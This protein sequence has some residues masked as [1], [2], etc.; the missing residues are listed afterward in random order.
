MLYGVGV[1][2]ELN[3]LI[4]LVQSGLHSSLTDCISDQTLSLLRRDTKEFA[5][6]SERD[7]HVEAGD[8]LHVVL[9]ASIL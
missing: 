3:Q 4:L 5:K 2:S 1:V 6:L 9:D 8:H 7:V